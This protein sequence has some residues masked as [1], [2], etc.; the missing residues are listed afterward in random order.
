M[1]PGEDDFIDFDW[2]DSQLQSLLLAADKGLTS[3][4][5]NPLTNS[6]TSEP[7]SIPDI[8]DL[9]T[10]TSPYAR[11]RRRRGFL[12]VSDLVRMEW[13][14]LQFHYTL[15]SLEQRTDTP[16]MKVGREIHQ[17]LELEV[18]DVVDVEIHTREDMWGLRLLNC[19]IG[20]EEMLITGKTRELNVFG[21]IHD[22][23]DLHSSSSSTDRYLVFGVID[24]IS[25]DPPISLSF[26]TSSDITWRLSDTKTRV[27]P[28]LPSPTT[29]TA[30]KFQMM[31][32]K[33]LFDALTRG[34]QHFDHTL[35]FSLLRLNP[36]TGF[37]H[38]LHAHLPPTPASEPWTLNTLLHATLTRFALFP[39][40]SP[41]LTL[42]YLW[43][44]TM[45][46]LGDVAFRHDEGVL[47]EHLRRA[48]GYWGGRKMDD[49]MKGVE[50]KEAYR[51][52][53]CEYNERCEWRARKA[54]ELAD[55]NEETRTE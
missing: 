45:E 8:E 4:I 15:E 9:I 52:H 1:D 34:P 7:P 21:F 26:P 16:A 29:N 10:S 37:S 54:Q 11:H 31:L 39:P 46:P 3:T 48:I 42:A 14:G 20:L 13:C 53:G 40:L 38:A 43:Q 55:G 6:P 22:D 36:A 41:T 27:H 19:L 2:H 35:F 5:Q 18:H 12:S 28:H 49:V 17:A 51:C 33:H 44:R 32:Y 30:P 24:E 47:R 25:R 50:V 23:N